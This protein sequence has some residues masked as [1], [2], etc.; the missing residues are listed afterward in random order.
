MYHMYRDFIR[1]AQ[2]PLVMMFFFFQFLQSTALMLDYVLIV[3]CDLGCLYF[4]VKNTVTLSDLVISS[5]WLI[6]VRV[7]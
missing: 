6:V 5:C 2:F 1:L 4:F 7:V 3:V